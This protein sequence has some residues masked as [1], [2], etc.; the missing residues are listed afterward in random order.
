ML[1]VGWRISCADA[2]DEAN[3]ASMNK[4]R[5]H[6][7]GP[8]GSEWLQFTNYSCTTLRRITKKMTS[9]E[10]IDK[11]GVQRRE[12]FERIEEEGKRG[13]LEEVELSLIVRCYKPID[14]IISLERS[15]HSTC[16]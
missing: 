3:R 16:F 5:G 13:H 15:G 1:K 2:T 9:D 12:G 7:R 10:M 14:F 11:N 4:G 8:S 6:A